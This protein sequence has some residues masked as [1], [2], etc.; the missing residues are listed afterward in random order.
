MP[1]NSLANIEHQRWS[2]WQRYV[3]QHGQLQP[4]GSLLLPAELVAHWEK[5]IATPYAQLGEQEKESDREQV[6]R[7]LPTI[8]K[9]LA[10]AL[11]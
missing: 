5:Q 3:H 4:D 6:R 1:S 8:S 10:D 11:P 2:T 9:A 7:Y